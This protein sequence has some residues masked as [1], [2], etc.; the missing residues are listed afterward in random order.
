[1]REA[2]KALTLLR[3]A[4]AALDQLEAELAKWEELAIVRG[5][6][7]EIERE[8]T[9]AA[10]AR[11]AALEEAL[12]A[13]QDCSPAHRYECS[14]FAP[15]GCCLFVRI[16]EGARLTLLLST[17]TGHP[18]EAAVKLT[19]LWCP[20]ANGRQ[21]LV[22]R[23]S[24]WTGG[25]DVAVSLSMSPTFSLHRAGRRRERRRNHRQGRRRTCLQPACGG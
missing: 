11:V 8:L 10:E 13:W 20:T 24:H 22:H 18:R 9:E 23:Q 12:W 21:I 3:G 19:I 6:K 15:P 1:V 2:R 5:Q 25:S 14:P 17:R 7:L 16:T 4:D